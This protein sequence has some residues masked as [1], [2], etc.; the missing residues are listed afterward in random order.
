MMGSIPQEKVGDTMKAIIYVEVDNRDKLERVWDS[1]QASVES[2]EVSGFFTLTI[3]G[4]A[5][6]QEPHRRDLDK[7]AEVLEVAEGGA[8]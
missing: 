5:C 7:L 3:D 6:L 8:K 2:R 1:L 4:K